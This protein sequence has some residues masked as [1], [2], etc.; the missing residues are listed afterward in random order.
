MKNFIK[1]KVHSNKKINE[2]HFE[3]VLN[4]GESAKLCKSGQ[5]LGVYSKD[6]SLIL[7]RPISISEIDKKN[8][9]ITLVIQNK[10][11]G[12]RE[13]SKAKEND[14]LDVILP[15][16][17]GYD[18]DVQKNETVYLMGGGV[19]IPPLVEAYKN[20]KEKDI[21]VKVILGF[22]DSNTF[23]ENKFYED[24]VYICT[25]DGSK[26]FKGNVVEKLKTIDKPDYIYT[27]GPKPMLR[28]ICE[29]AKE[30]NVKSFISVE[31]YMAC[32]IGVCLGCVLKV[33]ENGT[34][35]TKKVCVDGPVFRGEDVIFE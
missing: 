24:D 32:C 12:T 1:C 13:L 10:G 18:L 22:R 5:F 34:I 6:K 31:E 27:C 29:Y 25:D 15:L 17:N 23:L 26:G 7:P 30:N 20:L 8:H 16:G 9:R 33:R 19:G 28:G 14:V 21:N 11:K 4:V 2:N 3:L 35:T